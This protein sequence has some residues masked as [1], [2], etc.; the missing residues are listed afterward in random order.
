MFCIKILHQLEI[1]PYCVLPKLLFALGIA[2]LPHISP[3]FPT[4]PHISPSW[5]E[6]R[7]HLLWPGTPNKA[8]VLPHQLKVFLPSQ[9]WNRNYRFNQGHLGR[10]Q[11]F[12]ELLVDHGH[13][14]SHIQ[15][16]GEIT[17]VNHLS[18]HHACAD[19]VLVP[20]TLG[21][22]WMPTHTLSTQLRMS[23]DLY[24]VVLQQVFLLHSR[25]ELLRRL[26]DVAR[27]SAFSPL[28]PRLLAQSRASWKSRFAK[29]TWEG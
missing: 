6:Q 5:F 2:A 23:R 3:H 8:T 9:T 11:I 16:T 14:S 22:R 10:L 20:K 13:T 29:C 4:F 25:T 26:W 18:W 17:P 15:D 28:R 1:A 21:F 12:L 19:R 24:T 7:V 27:W